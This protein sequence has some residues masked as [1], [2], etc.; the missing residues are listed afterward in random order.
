[1]AVA[2]GPNS[3]LKRLTPRQRAGHSESDLQCGLM[4]LVRLMPDRY[5]E[6]ALLYAIPN[7]RASKG[8]AK[9]MKGEGTLRGVPDLCLPVARAGCHA[10]YLETKLPGEKLRPEQV[11]VAERLRREGNGV[12]VWRSIESAVALLNAYL[13]ESPEIFGELLD[14]MVE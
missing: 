7:Q 4:T 9:R 8:E 13:R 6:L 12:A 11:A 5:P 1:M 2:L 3:P 14:L 10:L